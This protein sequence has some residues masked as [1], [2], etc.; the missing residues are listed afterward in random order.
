MLLAR[1]APIGSPRYEKLSK[2]SKKL[3]KIIE[4]LPTQLFAIW[5]IFVAGM[6]AGKTNIDRHYFWDWNNWL[7]GIIGIAIVTIVINILKKRFRGFDFAKEQVTLKSRGYFFFSSIIILYIGYFVVSNF[8]NIG[9]PILYILPIIAVYLIHT[10]KFDENNSL[11]PTESHKYIKTISSSLLLIVAIIF[12]IVFDDPLITTAAIVSLPFFIILLF[13]KHIR[14]LERAKFYPIF[15]FAMFVSSREAWFIIPLFLL[16]F[17]LRSY[18]Y[19]RNQKIYPTFG[20]S[21]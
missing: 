21:E 12:G 4:W 5:S 11:I 2:S 16:F 18:N 14:H 9:N 19:L 6:S 15:I 20:V 8:I 1:Y 13:G 3:D 10:I 7:I 17:V